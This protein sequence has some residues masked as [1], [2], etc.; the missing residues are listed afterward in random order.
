M[1]DIALIINNGGFVCIFMFVIVF[2]YIYIINIIIILMK[3]RVDYNLFM[4]IVHLGLNM[5]ICKENV[6]L[7]L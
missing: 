7:L 2:S 3:N 1:R 5:C 6:L 4:Y